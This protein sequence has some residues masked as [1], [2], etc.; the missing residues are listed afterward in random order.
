LS[1]TREE[2]SQGG[3]EGKETEGSKN[4]RIPPL[5]LPSLFLPVVETRIALGHLAVTAC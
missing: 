3:D 4:P 1:I 5:L 2:K